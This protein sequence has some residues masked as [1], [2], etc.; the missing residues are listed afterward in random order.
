VIRSRLVSL[1]RRAWLTLRYLGPWQVLL[2]LLTFPLR[3]TPLGRRL[4]YGHS[5]GPERIKA[6]RWYREHGSPVT[7]VIPTYGDPSL[8]V[9]AVRS[10]RRTTDDDRVRI[11]VCDDAT[12]EAEH[13]A[14]LE[15]LRGAEVVLGDEQVGFARNANRGLRIAEG[16]VVL[17]NSDVLAHRG[18]LET[19]QKAA[20]ASDEIGM[21]APKLLYADGR[22]QSA[23]SHRNLE[24]PEWWDHRYR[25]QEAMYGPANVAAPVLA[26]T[27]AAL[28]VKAKTIE[29]VGLLDDL[30]AMAFEDV[31]WCLRT[32]RAGLSIVY[33]PSSELTHLESVTRG[34]VQG[35]R[36]LAAKD[37]FWERWGPWLDDRDV[38]TE[39][40]R[41]KVV[42]VTQ[43]TTVGGGHRDVFE[44]LNRLRERGHD[45]RLYTLGSGPPD[46]FDLRAPVESFDSYSELVAALA[47]LDTIK[48]ATWWET[49]IP[50]W[51]ASIHHGIAAYFVQDIETS[52][53]VG[54][55]ELQSQVADSYRHEFRY[56]TIS[57][58]NRKRLTEFGAPAHLVPPGVDHRTFRP[59]DDVERR[60][61]V[62][63][64]IGRGNPLKNLPLT[65][66]AWRSLG[67]ARPELWMFGVEP[68]WGE[69]AGARYDVAP[70]DAEVN[71]LLN[72][73]TVFVQTSRHEGF[74][75]PAL[76]A[77]AAGCPVICT[78]AHGNRD[79]CRDGENCLMPEPT[80]EAVAAAVQRV[81]TDPALR[82]RLAAEGLRT[83]AEYAWD[84][85]INQL[86]QALEE[87]AAGF[88]KRTPALGFT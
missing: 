79:F 72:E 83:A 23:G 12:P 38:R 82:E 47:P 1:P 10:V 2:R 63:L 81:L 29:R 51:R 55:Y 57:G 53:Y 68:E 46:W 69:R 76:E 22:I 80:K 78:D 27:G 41:L 28:Y 32:W 30:Y 71:R 26:A 16:D 48:V 84:R 58:W 4:G 39:D 25:F 77:M 33:E 65:L 60:E 86:E 21:A 24:F 31:D 61:N 56:L 37:L 62:A 8:T 19:L 6:R 75:L 49:A 15:R 67:D 44:H 66:D 35:E 3:P 18:W 59:L 14:R 7:V 42:Y 11:I 36:E 5:Y 74:C 9:K 20:Y 64:V 45:A 50:V 40:G 70:S 54:S 17:L 73:A 85:R 13:R 52:Y 34:T 43:D 87:V 88:L